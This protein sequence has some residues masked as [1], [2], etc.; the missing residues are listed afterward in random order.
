MKRG[1]YIQ[2]KTPLRTKTRIR[3]VGNS[4]TAEI[5]ERIQALLRQLAIQRDGGC[6]LRHYPE[7]GSCGGYRN[8]GELILQAEHLVTRSNS[9]SFADMRNI[10]C[11]CRHHHGHFKPEHSLEYWMLIER[12]IGLA[13][14]AWIQRVLNDRA[15]HRFYLADWKLAEV[16]LHRELTGLGI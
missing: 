1:G 15:P 11:L 14:W 13:R 8:T 2:R 5:K 3:V 16:A 9:V 7:A 12:H 4:D 6:I 10:V